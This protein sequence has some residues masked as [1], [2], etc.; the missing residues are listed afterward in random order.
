MFLEGMMIIKKILK[1]KVKTKMLK[2]KELFFLIVFVYLS[3]N[4]L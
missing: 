2:M 3:A 1:V 4:L